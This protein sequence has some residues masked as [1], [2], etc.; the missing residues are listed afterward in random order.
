M[1]LYDMW[2][3][4]TKLH[5][6][7]PFRV[8]HFLAQ[9]FRLDLAW[10]TGFRLELERVENSNWAHAGVPNYSGFSKLGQR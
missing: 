7:V 10:R 2:D 6:L 3:S 8:P 5:T 9:F 4:E 1:S